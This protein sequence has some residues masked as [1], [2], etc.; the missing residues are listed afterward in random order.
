LCGGVLLF[1][2]FSFFIV[3]CGHQIL[4]RFLHSRTFILLEGTWTC[5]HR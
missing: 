5:R 4:H 3:E 1:H 2:D